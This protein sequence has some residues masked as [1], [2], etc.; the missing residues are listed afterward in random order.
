MYVTQSCEL[1]RRPPSAAPAAAVSESPEAIAAVELGDYEAIGYS[2]TVSFDAGYTWDERDHLFRRKDVVSIGYSDG[3][4]VEN[5]LYQIV[6]SAADRSV[7]SSELVQHIK[8]WPTEYH[9]SRSRHCLLRPLNIKPGDLVLELGCGCGALTRYLGEVGANVVAVEGSLMRARIAAKRCEGLANV[10]IYADDLVHFDL[11]ETF[12]WVLLIGVL[13]YAPV[14]AKSESPVSDYL[15]R[16]TR[17]LKPGGKLVV[18][19][20]N[21]LGLKYFNG[22]SEDHLGRRYVGIEGLYQ[23]EQPVTFGRREL[24]GILQGA[25]LANVEVLYPFPDYKLPSVVLRDAALAHAGFDAG[26]LLARSHARDYLG[27]NLRNFD[28]ALV[29]DQLVRNGVL[30]DFSNSFLA[31]ATQHSL[32]TA[33]T[34]SLAMAFSPNRVAEFATLTRFESDGDGIFV[35]K[36]AMAATGKRTRRLEA[37]FDLT[38]LVGENAYL[39]GRQL[40]WEILAARAGRIASVADVLM[41][42]FRYLMD[43][44]VTTANGI[45]PAGVKPSLSAFQVDGSYLDCVPANLIR[46][47][48]KLQLI[49]CEWQTSTPIETGWVAT[50]GVL[51]TIFN[52][53]FGHEQLQSPFAVLQELCTRSGLTVTFQQVKRW[54]KL[55]A[56]FQ[57]VVLGFPIAAIDPRP[58]VL[59]RLAD[60]YEGQKQ[61]AA[62]RQAE[63]LRLDRVLQS[64][65]TIIEQG[66][67]QSNA[68]Q[69]ALDHLGRERAQLEEDHT[70]VKSSEQFWRAEL[71][72]A[73]TSRSWKLT[74]PVRAVNK[75][76]HGDAEAPAAS[77]A[78]NA[79]T[80]EA[81]PAPENL[82]APPQPPAEPTVVPAGRE[83]WDSDG[84]ARLQQLLESGRR[85]VLPAADGQ[86]EVS[87]VLVFYNNAHLSLLCLES[88]LANAGASYEVVIV[89]NASTD[90]TG[91]LLDRI[92]RAHIVRNPDN[93]GF[94]EA[95]V[96]GVGESKGRYICFLNNDAL[97]E[98]GALQAALDN[99][100]DAGVG[101]V[102]GKILFANGRLQEAGSMLWSDG[103]AWGYGRDDDPAAPQYEFRRLTD[104]CSAA[105]L[106]T[107]TDL[108]RE[109]GGFSPEFF[110]AYYED[111][112]Y[113]TKVWNSGRTVVYEPKAAIRHYESAAS[114]HSDAART[115]MARQQEK[116][117]AKWRELLAQH[118]PPDGENIQR[119]RYAA[120]AR[121]K[122]M[123]YL[124]DRIPHRDLGSGFP[125]SNDILHHLL[126]QGYHV[127]CASMSAPLEGNDYS[128]IDPTIELMDGYTHPDRL[129]F[130]YVR[131]ADLIWVTR[132]HNM[133]RLLQG[134]IARNVVSWAR[135]VYDAEAIFAERDRLKAELPGWL[136]APKVYDA[137]ASRELALGRG[138]DAVVCVS[139]RD[140]EAI[141]HHGLANVHVVGHQMA[142][143]PTPAPFAARRA[144]LFVGAMHQADS[145]NADSMLY[146]CR[147][148]WPTVQQATGASLLIAGFGSDRLRTSLEPYGAQVLGAQD[149][150]AALYNQ[151]RVFVVP[152]RYAAGIPYKAHEAAARGVPLVVSSLIGTQM[153]W[154]NESECLIAA[155]AGS[156]AD[157]CIRLFQDQALWEKLRAGAL[158][159]VENDLTEKRT[160]EAIAAVMN[161]LQR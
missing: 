21:K 155:D 36:E 4:E 108:F 126:R 66:S 98:P 161:S 139:E 46:S 61:L 138:A 15:A 111:T 83:A 48:D 11:G 87:I 127:T 63:I 62:G 158:A 117:V 130:E 144:F 107:P 42:W 24:I 22:C 128:D 122:W 109:L 13:E 116:F 131:K 80:S 153:G 70:K 25:G 38:N 40:T 16:A 76:L 91:K 31:V 88:I 148:I 9:L 8:D 100:H 19:I 71:E 118:L 92:D 106:V 149:N 50:R 1:R 26:D 160:S 123:L 3:F 33:V 43:S 97:L 121:G 151:A 143:Q 82:P 7:L 124:E 27:W 58:A 79:S 35:V 137:W 75:L 28:D 5:R 51:Y 93:R 78:T 102:G 112:D 60:E 89:D 129:F 159:R 84:R 45:T 6:A 150:L 154:Q 18:A 49:D 34:S 39:P 41:P 23:P 110:P 68:L 10:A 114:G 94:G 64:S 152:T 157:D 74:K 135:I 81:T 105:F 99:F 113:C 37:G 145:P 65:Q 90:D 86:P 136:I 53:V 57:S 95:C 104:Y 17:Y 85:L 59:L 52:G 69:Q 142:P 55:E 44:S 96:Q 47:G 29:N 30:A 103:S 115:L 12:D 146:F 119:G 101:A 20:E 67:R 54:L 140:C 134:M 56:E 72:K 156:F 2:D 141:T 147:E 120:L 14:Y 132:P 32:A 77:A 73:L 133:E 125:R